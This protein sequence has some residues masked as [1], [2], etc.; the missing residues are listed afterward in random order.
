MLN[1]LKSRYNTNMI[2]ATKDVTVK[3][4]L[5]KED[6]SHKMATVLSRNSGSPDTT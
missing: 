1:V 3:S 5:E 4:T 2:S 6:L